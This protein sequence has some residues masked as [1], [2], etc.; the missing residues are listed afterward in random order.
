MGL[1]NILLAVS[2]IEKSK[3]FY[4]EVFG[5]QVIRDFGENVMLSGGL[6]LQEK[7]Q[8]EQR[9]GAASAK[10]EVVVGTASALFFEERDFDAFLS[11][12]DAFSEI[13]DKTPAVRENSWGKRAVMIKDPDGHLLE[14]AE[15]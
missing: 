1:K 11:R 12:L 15:A 6:V 14:I 7:K 9:L 3:R 10:V 2:D 13:V 5:M 8:W 4:R